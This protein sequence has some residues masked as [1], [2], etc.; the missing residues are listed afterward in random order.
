MQSALNVS[1]VNQ[2]LESVRL[3]ASRPAALLDPLALL[4]ALEQLSDHAR[5]A[6]HPQRKKFDAIFKQCRPLAN[7]NSLAEVVLHLLGDKE[8]RDVASHIRKI[9][10]GH[11]SPRS[12]APGQALIFGETIPASRV[13]AP[14]P[15]AHLVVVD[16]SVH[17]TS[18]PEP[19]LDTVLIAE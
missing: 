16:A 8:E 13:Q 11:S 19:F 5:E 17:S 2:S 9:F 3:L 6:N 12:S 4:A 7:S 1:K 10:K 14:I 15:E 18:G